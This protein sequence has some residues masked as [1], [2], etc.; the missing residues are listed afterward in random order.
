MK[1]LCSVGGRMVVKDEVGIVGK[2]S[3]VVS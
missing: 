1:R 3:I 2:E